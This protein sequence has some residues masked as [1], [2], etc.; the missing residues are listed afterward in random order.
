MKVA[1]RFGAGNQAVTDRS[2]RSGRLKT[3][4]IAVFSTVRYA[5]YRS[6]V[7]SPS[8]KALGYYQSVRFAG[9]ANRL[10]QQIPHTRPVRSAI[11]D[12]CIFQYR[13]LYRSFLAVIL[14]SNPKTPV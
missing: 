7:V 1:Q 12:I 6:N 9:E 3:G 4:V 10:S 5:D 14:P 13:K 2:P 8:A 11:F